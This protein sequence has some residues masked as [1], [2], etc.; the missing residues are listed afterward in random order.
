MAASR[1]WQDGERMKGM[2]SEMGF[3]F[4]EYEDEADF[5]LFNTCAIR[6]HAEDRVFGN[7]GRAEKRE[8]PQPV[9]AHCRMRLHDGTGARG[10]AH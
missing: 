9:A 5:I 2:L 3:E 1:M 8:T 10:G 6:E 7:I 4:T